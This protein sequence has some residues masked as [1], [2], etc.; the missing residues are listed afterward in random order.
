MSNRL[1]HAQRD[2]SDGQ[3]RSYPMRDRVEDLFTQGVVFL[4]LGLHRWCDSA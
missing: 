2:G 1:H 3:Q 4:R